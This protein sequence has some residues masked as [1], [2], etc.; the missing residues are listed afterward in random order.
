MISN[1]NSSS[2]RIVVVNDSQ[3][4]LYLLSGLLEQ[5]GYEVLSF[6][7]VEMALES[8]S[9]ANGAAKQIIPDLL[10]TDLYMPDID[11]WRFCR[12]LRSP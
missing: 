2:S 6:Q 4:Q 8:M 5:Q 10:I 7:S 3:T 1:Q 9:R 11:G 12:L